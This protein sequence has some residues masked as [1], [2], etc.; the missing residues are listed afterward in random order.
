MVVFFCVCVWFFLC[1]FLFLLFFPHFLGFSTKQNML[2]VSKICCFFYFFYTEIRYFTKPELLRRSTWWQF[3]DN[4]L[5]FSIKPMP[6]V[7]SLRKTLP[8]S[9]HNSFLWRNKKMLFKD[10]L[11]LCNLI[12]WISLVINFGIEWSS[13]QCNVIDKY[14]LCVWFV[15]IKKLILKKFFQNYHTKYLTLLLKYFLLKKKLL[16]WCSDICNIAYYK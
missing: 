7:L 11:F 2:W 5:Q 4:I 15:K 16:R 12:S 13:L 10:Y 9:T 1:V 6:W 8:M 14:V 3:Y